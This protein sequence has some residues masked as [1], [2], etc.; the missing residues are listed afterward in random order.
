MPSDEKKSGSDLSLETAK[1][2]L[3][4]FGTQIQEY[5]SKVNANVESYKFSVEKI[6]DGI[7]VDVAFRA[8]LR[9]SKKS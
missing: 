3:V 4:A 5:L 9:S 1:D 6:E 8:T 7:S 2:Q